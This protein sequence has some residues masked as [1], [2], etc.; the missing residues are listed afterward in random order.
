MIIYEPGALGLPLVTNPVGIKE[1]AYGVGVFFTDADVCINQSSSIT[2]FTSSHNILVPFRDAL[3]GKLPASYT[4]YIGVVSMIDR[5][6][7]CAVSVAKLT[8]IVTPKMF[9][10]TAEWIVR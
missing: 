7:Y 10:G 3:C 6:A 8:N 2:S 1:I 5:G 9:D 4:C